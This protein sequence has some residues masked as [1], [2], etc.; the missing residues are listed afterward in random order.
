[1]AETDNPIA[2]FAQK[3]F[4]LGMGLAAVAADNAAKVAGK[5]GSRLFELRKQAQALL[6]ELVE[7]GAMS[8]EEARAFMDTMAANAN[9]KGEPGQGSGPRRISIDDIGDE[10]DEAGTAIELSEA[11]RLRQQIAELQAELDRIKGKS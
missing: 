5:A 4:Y 7:R 6:D 11:A 8:A 2:N 9:R 1:M 10:A 3:A